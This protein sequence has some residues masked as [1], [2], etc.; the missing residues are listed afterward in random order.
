MAAPNC[1]GQAQPGAIHVGKPSVPQGA[2]RLVTAQNRHVT[3]QPNHNI[4]PRFKEKH[5]L[6]RAGQHYNLAKPNY[7]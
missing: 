6:R 3:R 4:N 1:A 5:L 7:L 2:R